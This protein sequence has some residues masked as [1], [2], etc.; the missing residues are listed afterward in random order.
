MQTWAECDPKVYAPSPS[1]CC[2]P[3][4][5]LSWEQRYTLPCPGTEDRADPGH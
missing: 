1:L 3:S 4:P 2:L 5:G